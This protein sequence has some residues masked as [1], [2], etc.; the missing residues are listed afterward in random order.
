M[1]CLNSRTGG[2]DPPA[3][4]RSPAL[5]LWPASHDGT[6]FPARYRQVLSRTRILSLAIVGLPVDLDH[7]MLQH[8]R[9]DTYCL[10]RQSAS[11]RS[12]ALCGK[13]SS[14]YALLKS[15]KEYNLCSFT[16]DC[17]HSTA[18][19]VIAAGTAMDKKEFSFEAVA[20]VPFKDG[21]G[22]LN[23]AVDQTVR[24]PAVP[25]IYTSAQDVQGLTLDDEDTKE[26]LANADVQ[27]KRDMEAKIRTR[28]QYA[29]LSDKALP[30]V[31]IYKNEQRYDWL[32]HGP[33][34]PSLV[35][36]N[37]IFTAGLRQSGPLYAFNVFSR[38]ENMQL[39]AAAGR[40]APCVLT[41]I[42]AQERALDFILHNVLNGGSLA[43]SS[44][45]QGR[46]P[47]G[48]ILIIAGGPLTDKSCDDSKTAQ[49]IKQLR[50]AGIY[51]FVPA[52][53]DGKRLQVRFPGCASDAVTVGALDRDGKISSQSNGSATR[54]VTLYTD[55]DTLVLPIRTSP[56]PGLACMQRDGFRD[57]VIAYER[58][59]AALGYYKS[60][61]N[62]EL[63][64]KRATPCYG[65]RTPLSA[66]PQAENS[67]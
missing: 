34:R 26:R 20:A 48:A 32:E 36:S 23:G 47:I 46:P 55:G 33:S 63:D 62:G 13:K 66:S 19:A 17:W 60:E 61:P 49:D 39:C 51:T 24:Y 45:S 59:L 11:E 28:Q 2:R 40:K 10:A 43:Q 35:N 14:E 38:V 7:G 42:D 18:A 58:V 15:G 12:V 44:S 56:I 57:I 50:Q 8:N 54:M 30:L 5:V 25:T 65:F 53:N 21:T 27:Q 29:M 16:D 31:E 52:G 37:V 3:S 64:S 67:T 9:T 22:D 1:T 4:S 6:I 41:N